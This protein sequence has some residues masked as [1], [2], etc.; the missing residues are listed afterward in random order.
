MSL[1]EQSF[2]TEHVMPK[3]LTTCLVAAAFFGLLALVR[4]KVLQLRA[5][6]RGHRFRVGGPSFM[7]YVLASVLLP[8][9][10]PAM[11]G[12]MTVAFALLSIIA[13]VLASV[14]DSALFLNLASAAEHSI[15]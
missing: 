12:R 14:G 10:V 15:N 4:I 2:R 6:D 3:Q 11:R 8:R 1:C 7:L 5:T 13:L 9:L